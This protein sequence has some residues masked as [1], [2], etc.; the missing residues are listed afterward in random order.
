MGDGN[1]TQEIGIGG[2]I[3][4]RDFLKKVGIAIAGA[5]LAATTGCSNKENR[6]HI[7]SVYF[8][9]IQN[10]EVIPLKISGMG[11]TSLP[12]KIMYTSSERPNNLDSLFLRQ[13]DNKDT[14]LTFKK[15]EETIRLPGEIVEGK[16][17][18]VEGKNP[19]LPE[20][21]TVGVY[22]KL[23]GNKERDSD[24]TR[25]DLSGLLGPNLY[26]LPVIVEG[27]VAANYQINDLPQEIKKNGEG[28]T[29]AVGAVV[30]L[31][32]GNDSAKQFT[33]LG[34]VCDSRALNLK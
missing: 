21:T 4:R 25:T 20:G 14:F 28:R 2:Q 23:T 17:Y 1:S 18:H 26:V 27:A 30:G 29:F 9:E 22:K 6:E 10:N 8:R 3:T 13:E 5:G 34:V 33:P 19:E 7:G 16:L 15:G 12:V 32:Q 24:S 11:E 31:L